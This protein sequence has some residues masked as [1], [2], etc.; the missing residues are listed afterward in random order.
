IPLDNN[1][2]ER[3]IRSFCVGKHSWNVIGTKNGAKSS[4]ILYSIA[5]TAKANDLKTFEYFQYLMEQI[6]IHLDDDPRDYMESIM[7]WSKELPE[8]CFKTK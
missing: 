6:L 5:E 8:N 2:A 7:P 3:S 1:D 4:A